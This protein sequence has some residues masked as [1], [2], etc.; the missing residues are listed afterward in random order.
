LLGAQ[1]WC[2][3]IADGFHVHPAMLRLLLASCPIE[4]IMLVSD[5]MPPAGTCADAFMLQ[6]RKIFRRDGRLV[7]AD[8][9]LAGADLCLAEAVRRA[10]RL[11]GVTLAQALMM[12]SSAPAAFLGVDDRLGHIAPGF[13]ADLLLLDENLVVLGTWLAGD[14]QGDEESVLF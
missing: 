6:G 7:T 10:V 1:T 13:T 9:T 8:G 4:R 5:S 3:V 2:G 14:W 12:A 11:M